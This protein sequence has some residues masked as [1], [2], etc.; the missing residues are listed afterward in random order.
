MTF[1]LPS[2]TI[3]GHFRVLTVELDCP[4]T[5]SNLFTFNLYLFSGHLNY[6]VICHLPIMC[7]LGGME[8]F[9]RLSKRQGHHMYGN[10]TD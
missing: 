2:T 4:Y 6:S 1:K 8:H 10:C 9:L 3:I 5:I 7:V